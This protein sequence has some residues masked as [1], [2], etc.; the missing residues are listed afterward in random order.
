MAESTGI[1]RGARVTGESRD[2]LRDELKAEYEA[3]KSIRSLA[4][5]TGRSYGFV[6]NVL[7]EADVTLRRRGGPNRRKKVEH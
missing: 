7:V 5:K 6:H 4:E 1:S 2:R 3:G